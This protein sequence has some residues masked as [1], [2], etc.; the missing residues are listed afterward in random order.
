MHDGM[1][2]GAL[3]AG[4][5]LLTMPPLSAGGWLSA[6]PGADLEMRISAGLSHWKKSALSRY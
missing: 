3:P 2:C 6:D 5:E 4:R 1:P